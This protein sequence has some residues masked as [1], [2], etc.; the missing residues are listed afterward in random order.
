MNN[1]DPT[2]VLPDGAL[3]PAGDPA[4]EGLKPPADGPRIPRWLRD[5]FPTREAILAT[6]F[7]A[8]LCEVAYL[9][10]FAV[11]GELEL[12]SADAG[13]INRTIGWVVAIQT[14]TFY[15]RGLCHRPWRA[16]RF[17]DLN[18]LL[19]TATTAL[20]ILIAWNYFLGPRLL[21]VPPIPRKVLVL[22]WVFSIMAVGSMQ[23]I[24]RSVY[25][26]VAPATTPGSESGVIIASASP[27]G[28]RLARELGRLSEGRFFVSGLLDD[29]HELYGTRVGRARVLGPLAVAVPC[30]ERLRV[31]EVLVPDGTLHGFQL[32][33]LCEACDTAGIRVRV[34]ALV[35]PDTASTAAPRAASPPDARLLI[36]R[37]ELPDLLSRP[38]TRIRDHADVVGPFLR[39]RRVL[40][41][42][43]GGSIGSEICRQ[44]I[45]HAPHTLVL[46]ERSEAA[47]F[48]IH[49]ELSPLS[50]GTMVVPLL[51][52]I[53]SAKR[54]AN[55]LEEY[56]PEI[57]VHAAAYKHLPLMES[58]PVE[59]IENNTLATALLAEA[60]VA[61]GVE[62]FVALSTDKAVYP[63]SVM[64]ASKLVAERFL[65]ALGPAS[66]KRFV[67]VRFGNVIGSSGS[68]VPIFSERLRQGQ[69]IT[70]TH[71]DVRRYFMTIEEAARLVILAA[72]TGDSGG[73]FV[74]D[75]GESVRIVELVHAI[76][77]VMGLPRQAVRIEFS[78][79]RPGEK[80]DEE[81]FFADET[82][83]STSDDR[84]TCATRPERSLT[85]VRH[86]LAELR[87]AA[88][89]GPAA[90]RETLLRIV[91]ND[92]GRAA[93]GDLLV[94]NG[95]RAIGDVPAGHE[96][97]RDESPAGGVHA[98]PAGG[99]PSAG[100]RAA[101]G[102]LATV[103]VVPAAT[104][105][106]RGPS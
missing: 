88:V 86:W 64:G 25:E 99:P 18:R 33:Q 70:V 89:C 104:E 21:S 75:M 52:D 34:A 97:R 43:A 69:S 57:V 77:F 44:L 66:G 46:V 90:A 84:V 102:G 95:G 98:T 47:L 42:G 78:G 26:E 4:L 74:L 53:T 10:A 17:E 13:T 96:G 7:V 91:A 30:A 35:T 50:G 73:L 68:A 63:S 15:F 24:A 85:E 2:S 82:R 48:E 62:T 16:A 29:D 31:R 51:V 56:R 92:C 59:A 83:A 6:A 100:V 65:Q 37:V 8:V 39:D 11:R 105:Q 45:R 94:A 87:E 79:L 67:V 14:L 76:A 12:Q 36:R 101:A 93:S 1:P 80:L 19:R 58:H 9:A 71:P 54:V 103:A 5:L 28:Q 49:R 22:D 72:A 32:R 81:L 3:A 41:T 27:D 20:L 60:C 23:A 106:P 55:V 40:V 61:A 38:T